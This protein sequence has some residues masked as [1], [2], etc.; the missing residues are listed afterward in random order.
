MVQKNKMW[1]D[2]WRVGIPCTI[3]ILELFG[4]LDYLDLFKLEKYFFKIEG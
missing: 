4:T 3:I 2:R 1:M